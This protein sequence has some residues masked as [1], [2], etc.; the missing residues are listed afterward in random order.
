M[1]AYSSDAWTICKRDESRITA[2]EMKFFRERQAV[3]VWNI[4]RSYEGIK[5]RTDHG[6]YRKLNI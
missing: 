3:L 5:Y 1:L 2:T 4:D 6:I